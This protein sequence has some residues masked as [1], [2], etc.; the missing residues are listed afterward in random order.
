MNGTERFD[1]R[2]AVNI[3]ETLREISP[4]DY[5]RLMM[6]LR[7][8]ARA[9]GLGENGAE[10]GWFDKLLDFGQG[11][12]QTVAQYKMGEL[13]DK[14]QQEAFERQRQIELERAAAEAARARRI[15]A[16]RQRMAE[17]AE[18]ARQQRE[19]ERARDASLGTAI[20]ATGVAL[21]LGAG[22]VLWQF[23]K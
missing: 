2:A 15:A 9:S 10:P 20:S 22:L 7:A 4:P 12:L 23:L 13:A 14:E 5:Q 11:A 8:Q 3:L 16:E 6:R 1:K 21:A 17:E 19:I 18:L